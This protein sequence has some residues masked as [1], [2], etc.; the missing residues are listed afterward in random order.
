LERFVEVL[1]KGLTKPKKKF[2]HQMLFG[3][4]ASR[5]IKLSEIARSLNEEIKLLKRQRCDYP[6]I[7]KMRIFIQ[8]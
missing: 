7:C 1:S 8:K 2:I 4:Q 3:I 6:E 5:D